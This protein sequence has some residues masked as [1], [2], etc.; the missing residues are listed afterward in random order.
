MGNDTLAFMSA[1][2]LAAAIRA[3]RLS[4]VGVTRAALDRI[5]RY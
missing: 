5:N 4:P 3:R 1:T 2:D